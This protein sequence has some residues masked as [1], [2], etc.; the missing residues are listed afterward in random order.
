MTIPFLSFF[1]KKATKEQPTEAPA[2][3]AP[4]EKPSSERLSKTVMPN[5]TRTVGNQEPFSGHFSSSAM[6]SA[7]APSAPRTI[8]FGSS[9]PAERQGLPPAVA[10]ALEPTVERAISLELSDVVSH[11]PAGMVRPL[12]NGDTARRVLLK[13][14]ELEKGM[15]RGKPTVS[16]T[17]IFQQVPEIFTRQIAASDQTQ[18]HLPMEKVLEQ[19]SNLQ[20][21]PDQADA[22]AVPYVET[23]FLKVTLEDDLK[24]GTKTEVLK[25]GILPR[26]RLEPAT[27]E[28]IAAAEPEPAAAARFAIPA[29]PTA[30]VPLRV[31]VPAEPTSNGNGHA[32]GNG[33]VNRG[34]DHAAPT[35]PPPAEPK[36]ASP[37]RIPFKL[38]PNGTDVPASERVPASS[39][40]SVPTTAPAPAAK[41][42]RIPFKVSAPDEEAAP[43]GEPWITKESLGEGADAAAE[44]MAA[45]VPVVM[46][47]PQPAQ[48]AH[49]SVVLALKPILHSLP[50]F[51]L[52]GD[53]NAVPKD[54]RV[55]L[56]FALIEPQLASGRIALQPKDFAKALP[57]EFRSL[58][59][60]EESAATVSLP[61]QE[62]LKNLPSTTL[63]M[64]DDQIEQ[65]KGENFATPFSAKAEEDAKRFN[66]SGT[67]VAKPIAA[68]EPEPVAPVVA[69]P[70][71][72]ATPAPIAMP[73]IAAPEPV[74]P[75]PINIV[76]DV[77]EPELEATPEEHAAEPPT[78]T[79]LQTAFDTDE[80]L[81][82]KTVVAHVGKM[83]GVK[84][85]AI[86]FGDGLSLAGN[87]PEEYEADGL[88]AMAP[89]LLQRIENHMV[90]T[91]LGALRAMTL[92]CSK[93]AVT[94]FMHD[95]LCLAALH[96][97]EEL[98]SDV[99]ERLA[100]AVHELS[101]KYSN[102]A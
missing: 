47:A 48:P 71:A 21:R 60:A 27:A 90:E 86:M 40:P 35:A 68:P 5:A 89:S 36:P 38:T 67:P 19:F 16:L 39:G 31:Q 87:L 96:S 63:R 15:A 85:C 91:K 80:E 58:F 11:L 29:T 13:A 30:P 78:R 83:A 100:R 18:V 56:P 42:A 74:V 72:L 7:P 4:I 93:A 44:P 61:L 84:A 55:E 79:A 45:R 66:I 88:C 1:K 43:K 28:S 102:P 23:P 22:Q 9:G 73:T 64:R 37:A 59:N 81:D 97:K 33:V 53:I 92:S 70:T 6:P 69:E 8:S 99:R 82:A 12:Q 3:V 17:S 94:F 77:A 20:T 57:E 10:L 14:S 52:V 75:A 95:N 34:N 98:A 50:P 62:V 25:T 101:K 54:A 24:F 51:Q 32:S 76:P 49:L 41:P 46:P 26:V 2:P 65:E